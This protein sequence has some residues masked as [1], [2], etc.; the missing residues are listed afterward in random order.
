MK[1]RIIVPKVSKV[2]FVLT[3]LPFLLTLCIEL[4]E[5]NNI[6]LYVFGCSVEDV[7]QIV[8]VIGL[9]AL[10]GAVVFVVFK[11]VKSKLI[12][13]TSSIICVFFLGLG[14]FVLDI[15][16]PVFDNC[17][18]FCSEDKNHQIV[19]KETSYLL[20]GFG[21]IYEKTSDF[22]MT[23][24]ALYS[25]DDGFLPVENNAYEFVWYDT[26]F[27]FCYPYRYNEEYKVEKIEYVK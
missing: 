27:D 6:Y 17:Y 9:F 14:I 2:L 4:L 16:T 12:L 26:G 20:G 21:Y 23:E 11:N 13:A 10:I 1:K 7:T 5:K 25:T 3:A 19:V 15:N 22:T 8:T 24:I 18:E